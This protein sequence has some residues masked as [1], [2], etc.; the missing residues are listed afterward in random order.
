M[1]RNFKTQSKLAKFGTRLS[2]IV[3]EF[4]EKGTNYSWS[5][6]GVNTLWW[7]GNYCGPLKKLQIWSK[8]RITKW[9]DHYLE[10]HHLI[11]EF[12]QEMAPV[13]DYRI[14][15]FWWQGEASMPELVKGCYRQLCANHKNVVLITKDNLREYC[16]IPEYILDKC[17][18]SKI[19]L[20]HLSDLVRVSLLAKFGGLYLDS[21]C[22]IPYRIPDEVFQC[23]WISP[24]TKGMSEAP[25]WSD[26]RWTGWCMGTNQ[27]NNPMFVFC[28][29]LFYAFYKENSVVPFYLFIDYLYDYV[30]RHN[31]EIKAL[32]D[33]AS[34]TCTKRGLLHANLNSPWDEQKYNE[35]CQDNWV[36]KCS[37]KSVWKRTTKDGQLT[38]YGKLFN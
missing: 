11:P 21:T 20:T 1:A 17:K 34:E 19:T 32:V 23:K 6:G 5:L 8:H 35:L 24:N 10:S 13:T 12:T 29:D 16:D 28:R 27:S 4:F 3:E 15:V 33:G 38:F 37:Y 2:M 9:M 31:K 22:W 25:W 7:I 14:W 30:Y 18:A 26:W 36:F